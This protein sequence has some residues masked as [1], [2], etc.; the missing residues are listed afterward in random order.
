MNAA[1]ARERRAQEDKGCLLTTEPEGTTRSSQPSPVPPE[2]ASAAPG[3]LGSAGM[4]H[5][6]PGPSAAPVSRKQRDASAAPAA[7]GG[8]T[9]RRNGALGSDRTDATE[10]VSQASV[11]QPPVIPAAVSERN[12]AKPQKRSTPTLPWGRDFAAAIVRRDD[13]LTAI[14][15]KIDAADSPRVAL[16]AH[17]GNDELA[18]PL[19]MRRLRRYVDRSGKDVM[20]VTRSRAIHA[21]AREV[22]LAVVGNLKRVDFERYGRTGI[23]IGGTLV[24]LPGLGTLLRLAAILIALVAIGAA[25]LLYLPEATITLYPTLTPQRYNASVTLIAAATGP[26]G[27]GQLAAQRHSTTVTRQV[28]FPVHGTTTIKAPDG[29]D[30]QVA[31]PTDDDIQQATAF[32]QQVLLDAGRTDLA[33]R[34]PNETFVKQSATL[35]AFTSKASAKAG[36]PADLLRITA[37]G[38]VTMLSADND[39]LRGLLEKALR[40][41]TSRQQMFVPETFRASVLSAG[42]YDKENSQ[43]GVV[44]SLEESTTLAFSTAA[45]RNAV[46][47]K[48]RAGAEQAIGERVDQAAPVRIRLTPGWAPWLPRFANRITV[49]IAQQPPA[50]PAVQPS[51][52]PAPR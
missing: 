2:S 51:P 24:P 9:D 3:P 14:F 11:S 45:L 29:S 35:S 31:A 8:L 7:A 43:I 18:T 20:I 5:R 41:T 36:E 39:T 4:A 48:S 37:S 52:T 32:A 16:V 44:F 6:A 26:L 40:P 27:A 23:S 50:P 25:G 34:F 46:A 33:S 49:R 38:Q 15:G 30:Q 19:G 47:G 22:G 28:L 17:H 12:L 10:N 1:T 42:Q 13:T 21:R